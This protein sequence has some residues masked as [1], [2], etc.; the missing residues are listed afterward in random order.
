M[1]LCLSVL[2]SGASVWIVA[3]G[4]RF[5]STLVPTET[6]SGRALALM[7]HD[8]QQRPLAF[9]LIFGHSTLPATDPVVRDEVASAVAPLR[10]HPR[11]L[12]VRTAWDVVPPDPNRLSRDGRLTLVTV[13]LRGHSTAVES[14]VFA[15][16]GADAYAELRP[17]VRS[18]S[19]RVTATG[20]LAL[21]RRALRA[22]RRTARA[23]LSDDDELV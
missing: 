15:A 7:Q 8:L 21:Q 22:R 17:L 16:A 23:G 11:V 5:D 19:L 1:V 18:D 20:A 9:H 14:M 12:A 6:E 10:K 4:G 3:H 13:E 2:S